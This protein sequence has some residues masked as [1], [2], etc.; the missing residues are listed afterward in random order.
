MNRTPA[1]APRTERIA[2]AGRAP[3]SCRSPSSSTSSPSWLVGFAASA[4]EVMV[5]TVP[6]SLVVL[7]SEGL[8]SSLVEE[9]R[10]C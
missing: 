2:T 9:S 10:G 1:A 3:A 8:L 6:S 5:S 7:P 4:Y